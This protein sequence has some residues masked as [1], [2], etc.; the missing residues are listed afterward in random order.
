MPLFEI[1]STGDVREVYRFEA[2][3]EQEARWMLESGEVTKAVLTE[4]SG[5]RV[6]QIREIKNA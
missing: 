1:E 4:V 2:D 6:L 3:T 5:L